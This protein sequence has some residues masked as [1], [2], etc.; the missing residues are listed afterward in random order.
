LFH[1]PRLYSLVSRN[2]TDNNGERRNRKASNA[3]VR[4]ISQFAMRDRR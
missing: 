1:D 4:S 3:K 2:V